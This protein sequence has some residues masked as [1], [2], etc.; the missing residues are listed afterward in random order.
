[1]TS[2]QD[3]CVYTMNQNRINSRIPKCFFENLP[4]LTMQS[5]KMQFLIYFIDNNC[6]K[7]Y[8]SILQNIA[9][10]VNLMT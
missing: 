5:L 7:F 9:N 10:I 6:L 2:P 8:W 4:I 3:I 1:M